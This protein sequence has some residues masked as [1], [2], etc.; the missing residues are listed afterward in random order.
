MKVAIEYV[1]RPYANTDGVGVPIP[2]D[3]GFI[4][5]LKVCADAR[6]CRSVFSGHRA[7]RISRPG[8]IVGHSD[9]SINIDS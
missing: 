5:F 2:G 4:Y 6:A 8:S 7:V 1:G 9:M 3:S